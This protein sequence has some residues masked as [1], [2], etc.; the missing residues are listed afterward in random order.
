[1]KNKQK[2]LGLFVGIVRSKSKLTMLLNALLM[3]GI[4]AFVTASIMEDVVST[5]HEL[6]IYSSVVFVLGVVVDISIAVFNNTKKEKDTDS[7]DKPVSDA[8]DDLFKNNNL[9]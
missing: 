9:L 4:T 2:N 3:F 6:L 7:N 8:L 5:W 1:M